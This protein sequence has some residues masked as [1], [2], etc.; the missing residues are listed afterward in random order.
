M[1][2]PLP[3]NKRGKNPHQVEGEH[4]PATKKNHEPHSAP[5]T[6]PKKNKVP[7]AGEPPSGG[8]NNPF[9]NLEVK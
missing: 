5:A 8:I 6:A 9:A 1:I 2:S 4:P 7:V 3:R